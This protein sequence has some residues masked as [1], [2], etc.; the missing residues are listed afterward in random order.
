M[1]WTNKQ[2]QSRKGNINMKELLFM[3]PV[4]KEAVW[5]GRKLRDDFGYEIPSDSTGECWGIGAHKNGDCEIAEGTY[6]GE[7]LSKLWEEHPECLEMKM[8]VNRH[9]RKFM[10]HALR[11]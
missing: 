7:H 4:F 8:E 10:E 5:G 2:L 11:S 3:K 9:I 6:K 1:Q